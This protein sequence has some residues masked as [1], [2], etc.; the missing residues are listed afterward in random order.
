MSVVNNSLAVNIQNLLI[1]LKSITVLSNLYEIHCDHIQIVNF[2][3][4]KRIILAFSSHLQH[5]FDKTEQLKDIPRLLL[6]V[7]I[8]H[9]S[10][11]VSHDFDKRNFLGGCKIVLKIYSFIFLKKGKNSIKPYSSFISERKLLFAFG[12]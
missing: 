9:C 12:E 3:Y 6:L 2:T 10:Y 1:N 5:L 8:S 11:C 4:D 7:E